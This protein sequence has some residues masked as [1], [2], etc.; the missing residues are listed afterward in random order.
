MENRTMGKQQRQGFGRLVGALAVLTAVA[1]AGL[2]AF[3][4]YFARRIVTPEAAEEPLRV[5]E[6][7]RKRRPHSLTLARGTDADLPGRQY[8]FLFDGGTGHARI[9][10]ILRQDARTVERELL[11]V[12][13]GQLSAGSRGRVTGW[14]FSD[15]RQLDIE[16]TNV[17]IET[18]IGPMPA[19]LFG[20]TVHEQYA[21]HVHGRAGARE[22]TLRGVRTLA[23]MGFSNLVIS[24][25]NDPGVPPSSDGRYGL[26]TSEW[27]DVDAA[28]REAVSRGAQRIVLVGWSMG[29]TAVLIAARESEHRDRISEL[30]LESPAISWP[31]IIEHHGR[32]SR[33]PSVSRRIG[34]RAMENGSPLTGLGRGIPVNLLTPEV[35]AA[36][37]DQRT[38]VFASDGDT[39]VPPE[40][41]YRLAELRPDIVTLERYEQGEHV[42]LW[43]VDPRRWE[44]AVHTFLTAE[45]D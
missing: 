9:G 7:N 36:T 17:V 38:L 32:R 25:R 43:N 20:P 31:E 28:I 6:V 5:L 29:A 16:W 19:W 27:R 26:G 1:G 42:K 22:E 44:R 45:A 35:F 21:I 24:Y 18:D 23:R 10:L 12:E 40:A 30:I 13:T 11:S 8:S 14:W 41:A 37:L 15:P 34:I 39:F 3:G 4:H 2:T 33:V